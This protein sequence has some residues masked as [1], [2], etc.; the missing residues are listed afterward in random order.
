MPDPG[1][2]E[3]C[4]CPAHCSRCAQA[5]S[6]ALPSQLGREQTLHSLHEPKYALERPCWAL[7]CRPLLRRK[8]TCGISGRSPAENGTTPTSHSLCALGMAAASTVGQS[9]GQVLGP[10][11]PGAQ[12]GL[13]AGAYWGTI[14]ERRKSQGW[15]KS[16]AKATLGLAYSL[17]LSLWALRPQQ[18]TTWVCPLEE[19]ASCSLFRPEMPLAALSNGQVFS[20]RTD[21]DSSSGHL[22]ALGI[23]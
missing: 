11:P 9:S 12:E 10:E 15:P 13:W 7:T 16:W 23:H 20:L 4:G 2:P 18:T 22:C 21:P 14:E 3:F 19:P 1:Q 6:P 17:S 8:H 5:L